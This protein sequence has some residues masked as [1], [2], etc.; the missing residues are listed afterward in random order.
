MSVASVNASSSARMF[1]G[2]A[3]PAPVPDGHRLGQQTTSIA[4]LPPTFG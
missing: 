1:P 4:A 2:S 3:M